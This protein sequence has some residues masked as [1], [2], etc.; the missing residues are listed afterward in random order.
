VALGI[1][2]APDMNEFPVFLAKRA[3]SFLNPASINDW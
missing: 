3:F 1:D 2:E